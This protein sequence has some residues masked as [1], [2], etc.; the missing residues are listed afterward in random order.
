[1]WHVQLVLFI[2]FLLYT[3]NFIMIR[4]QKILVVLNRCSG[5]FCESAYRSLVIKRPGSNVVQEITREN[6][7]CN[8]CSNFY[9]FSCRYLNIRIRKFCSKIL[10][11]F[12]L[13][14]FKTSIILSIYLCSKKEFKIF[15][16]SE[17]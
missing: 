14:I 7:K 8:F 12:C 16:F 9:I 15:V 3:L 11:I 10:L 2:K 1:M 4:H 13:R 17:I 5:C 6:G